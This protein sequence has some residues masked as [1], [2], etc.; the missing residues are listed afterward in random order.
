[1]PD[2]PRYVVKYLFTIVVLYERNNF[3]G[4]L[5][6]ATSTAEAPSKNCGGAKGI[7]SA[8]DGPTTTVCSKY[9]FGKSDL[10]YFL[11]CQSSYMNVKCI[12]NLFCR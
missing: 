7:V 6:Q 2:N 10:K 12:C 8:S 9:Y 11:I 5:K 3:V 1:M 4:A